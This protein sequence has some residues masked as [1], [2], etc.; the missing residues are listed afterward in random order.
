LSAPTDHEWDIGTRSKTSALPWRGQFTPDLVAKFFERFDPKLGVVLDPFAG[1]GTVLLESLRLNRPSIGIEV[2][3]AACLLARFFE[4]AALNHIERETLAKSGRAFVSQANLRDE[5]DGFH[6]LGSGI[7]ELPSGRLRSFLSTILLLAAKNGNSVDSVGLKRAIKQVEDTLTALPFSEASTEIICA[8]A[9]AIPVKDKI[10]G[11][12]VTSPPYINVFNYHQNYRPSVELLGGNVLASA[13]SEIGSNRKFRGNRFLTVV[14]Y[15]I[16]LVD[17]AI[18]LER[19]MCDGAIAVLVVGRESRVLGVSFANSAIAL[20]CLSLVPRLKLMEKHERRFTS[21]YGTV[22]YEDILVVQKRADNQVTGGLPI[23]LNTAAQAIGSSH[24][25]L[26]LASADKAI[27][28]LLE[29][30]IANSSKVA[31]SPIASVIQLP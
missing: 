10:V 24:L 25:K 12:V 20:D 27:K 2:N 18:E 11:F 28:D 26:G 19:V 5:Q 6:L 31:A 7:T 4:F 30:A 13:V 29:T 16:D 14:Q 23:D 21:R 8:D 17:V 3:P 1:S 15:A 22:V 9:R